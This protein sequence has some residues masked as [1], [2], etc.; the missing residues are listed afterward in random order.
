[1]I[2][3]D[4]VSNLQLTILLFNLLTILYLDQVIHLYTHWASGQV[5]ERAGTRGR[6]CSQANN[7]HYHCYCCFCTCIR[8]SEFKRS[9]VCDIFE[10]TTLLNDIFGPG[11]EFNSFD[12]ALYCAH[13]KEARL[14]KIAEDMQKR[15]LL[16]NSWRR[17]LTSTDSAR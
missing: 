1:M 9:P 16:S 4:Q 13:L 11:R 2:A 12:F 8:C 3:L 7:H 14:E 17:N 15:K 6:A 5:G 10:F